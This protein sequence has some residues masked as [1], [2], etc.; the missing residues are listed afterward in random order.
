MSFLP[1]SSYRFRAD[2]DAA[3]RE[4]VQ[5]PPKDIERDDGRTLTL[6]YKSHPKGGR[7]V[8]LLNS[9]PGQATG[10]SGARG[11]GDIQDGRMP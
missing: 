3:Q 4:L 5:P 1:P 11:S 2:Q 10:R 7:A 9:L 6:L 8:Y